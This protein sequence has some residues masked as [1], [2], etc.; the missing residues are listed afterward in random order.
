MYVIK[1]MPQ[2]LPEKTRNSAQTT[3]ESL[4]RRITA[5]MKK[6]DVLP[7]PVQPGQPHPKHTRLAQICVLFNDELSHMNKHVRGTARRSL[8]IIANAT[9][10]EIWE[11]LQPYKDRLLQPIY[12]KPLRALPFSTQIG[13]IDAIAYY[14]SLKSDFVAFDDNLNRLLMESLALADATDESLAGKHA[15]FRTHE[16]IVNLRVSCIKLL[17]KAMGFDEFQKGQNNPTRTKIVSVFF[18][19]LYSE[20]KPTIEAAND[21]LKAVLSQT[22]KLPKDLLQQGLRPVL[23][24]L[25]DPKRLSTHGLD[26]LARLLR[27]LT[28]Y[29]KVEIGARLLDHIKVL[30]DPNLLQQISFTFFEQNNQM[31]VVAAVFNIFHLLPP[32]AEQFK[33]RLIDTCLDL[34]EKLRRTH[35]SSFRAPLYKY[36]NRYPAEVW[37]L[38]VS[39]SEDLKYGRFLAQVLLD[40]ESKPLREHAAANIDGLISTC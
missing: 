19:C 29:F 1:D 32:A 33:E 35:H 28:T 11:L 24:N 34:E 3:L 6:E 21:S 2:D 7:A 20:S 22:N 37:N 10:V 38:L 26:N 40:P 4:L 12:A 14:M 17:S 27:L 16:S 18:K 5:N 30:A 8:E 15:E 31:K 36:L 23:A 9:K 13:Y 25:Q 39:K